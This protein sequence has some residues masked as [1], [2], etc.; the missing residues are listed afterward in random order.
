ME[1]IG[2]LLIFGLALYVLHLRSRVAELDERLTALEY[3]KSDA[4]VTERAP[5]MPPPIPRPQRARGPEAM[6]EPT[7]EP[8]PA[9]PVFTWSPEPAPERLGP[10]LSERLRALI[11]NDEWEALLGGSILNK[12]GALVLVVGIALFLGFSFA[13]ITAGGRAA[14]ALT[15]SLAILGTGV[16]VERREKY[17]VFARGLIGGGWAAL[18]ATAYAIYAIPA[19]QIIDNPTAGSLLLLGVGTGMILHSLRYR[20]QAVTAVAYFSAF[21]AL[22]VTP[23][24]PFA[25]VSLIPLAASILYLAAK[26]DWYPMALF[27]LIATYGTCV[28]RGSSDA[29]LIEVQALFFVYWL[30]FELFDLLRVKRRIVKGGVEWIYYLNLTGFVWL[31]W[32]AWSHHEPQRLWFASACGAALFCADAIARGILRPPS[33]FDA[34]DGPGERLEAGS[35]EVSALVSAVLGAA[36]LVANVPGVWL[37]AGLA[38]EAEVLYLLGLRFASPFLQYLGIA[39]FAHSLARVGLTP[40]GKNQTPPLAFHA[41]LFYV[42]RVLRRPNVLM[43]T[44]A[45]VVAAVAIA[46]EAPLADLGAAWIVFAVALFEVGLRTGA[47]DLRMQA[48]VLA[49]AGVVAGMVRGDV[50][51]LAV[52]L[53]LVLGC[54]VRSRWIEMEDGEE[55]ASLAVAASGSAMALAFMLLWHTVPVEYV[56]LSW[57]G[58]ALAALELGNARLPEEMRWF[59]APAGAFAMC[60]LVATHSADFAKFAAQPVWVSVFGSGLISAACAFRAGWKSPTCQGFMAAATALLMAGTWL[61]TPDLYVSMAWSA[62]A[63]AVLELEFREIAAGAFAVVFCGLLG[64]GLGPAPLISTPPAIAA[65]YWFWY[66]VRSR[67]VFWLAPIP[68]VWLLFRTAGGTHAS[69]AYMGMALVLLAG[70]IRFRIRDARLQSYIVAAMAFGFAM[71]HRELQPSLATIALLYA[72]QAIARNSEERSAA[73]GFSI[74][75]STL[76][77]ALLGNQVSGGMLTVSWGLESDPFPLVRQHPRVLFRSVNLKLELLR[78]ERLER[79]QMLKTDISVVREPVIMLQKTGDKRLQR[80]RRAEQ[81]VHPDRPRKHGRRSVTPQRSSFSRT[82]GG[83]DST[84]SAAKLCSEIFIPGSGPSG[85]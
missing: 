26:F 38:L 31:S 28:S 4:P 16:W 80:R 36:A 11:G 41:L 3:R 5:V 24:S 66:R 40:W 45:A 18:Y 68:L 23:S 34:A 64:F 9:T 59:A 58:L 7:T 2:Y 83:G 70:G 14:M 8:V 47:L 77:A 60:G 29:P 20:S 30:L 22:T 1:L 35:F 25:V 71:L 55:R 42:N 10:S 54:A 53:E 19:A 69:A 15:L 17:R 79:L 43:S 65:I 50:A 33:T 84:T 13:H 52:S 73:P 74:S 51:S 39:A 37:S 61:V 63:V 56:V 67:I 32:L 85:R 75:A 78:I 27:G 6:P 21:A 44:A 12:L 82:S 46:I 48:Y 57:F 76:L 62:I 81:R 49:S 72:G